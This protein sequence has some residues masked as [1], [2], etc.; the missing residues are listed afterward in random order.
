MLS[1]SGYYELFTTT[2][3]SHDSGYSELFAT[4]YSSTEGTL[5]ENV[6]SDTSSC[7]ARPSGACD[8]ALPR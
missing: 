5:S 4:T 6:L 2:H 8:P 7:R 3:S 1:S